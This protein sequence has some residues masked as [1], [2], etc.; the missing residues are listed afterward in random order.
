MDSGPAHYKTSVIAVIPAAGFGT[1]INPDWNIDDPLL[2]YL[3]KPCLRDFQ[4]GK[5]LLELVIENVEPLS[6]RILVRIGDRIDFND[7]RDLDRIAKMKFKI[8]HDIKEV[9]A[10]REDVRIFYNNLE[11]KDA[12]TG[13]T[14]VAEEAKQ[15]LASDPSAKAV[16]IIGSD[17]PTI[18]SDELNQIIS[19]H[20]SSNNDVTLVSV[21]EDSAFEH[22]RIVRMPYMIER[23][24]RAGPNANEVT[25]IQRLLNDKIRT[26]ELIALELPRVAQSKPGWTRY[27]LLE[28]DDLDL[29]RREG[30]MNIH[31]PVVGSIEQDCIELTTEA[32]E[33]LK[34]RLNPDEYVFFGEESGTFLGIIEQGQIGLSKEDR[35]RKSEIDVGGFRFSAE[36]LNSIRERNVLCMVV[37]REV[38]LKTIR[39]LDSRNYG[40]VL[41]SGGI[42]TVVPNV[43]FMAMGHG[44]TLEISGLKFSRGDLTRITRCER[45]ASEREDAYVLERHEKDEYY[46]PEVANVVKRN[47]GRVGVFRLQRGSAKGMD[48]RTDLRQFSFQKNHQVI[49]S[50][51]K[52]GV[53]VRDGSW[54]GFGKGFDIDG[55]QPGVS[56][57]G[58][59][60]LKGRIFLESGASL[61]DS[62]IIASP[63]NSLRIGRDS[64]VS[65][66]IIRDSS[67]GEDA[68]VQDCAL[69]C[70][71]V[72]RHS[73]A[74]GAIP[75]GSEF[76]Q[77]TMKLVPLDEVGIQ[78][79]EKIFGVSV[80]PNAIIRST[81]EVSSFL[82]SLMRLTNEL[83]GIKRFVSVLGDELKRRRLSDIDSLAEY[84]D[85]VFEP[86]PNSVLRG[87]VALIPPLRLGSF[88]DLLDCTIARSNLGPFA[89]VERSVVTNCIVQSQESEISRISYEELNGELIESGY[90]NLESVD[91]PAE[92]KISSWIETFEDKGKGQTLMEEIYG[93]TEIAAE[94]RKIYLSVLRKSKKI[95][96]GDASVYLIRTPGRVNLMGRHVDH[97]GCHVNPIA[98][99]REII[100]IAEPRGDSTVRAWDVDMSYSPGE[101]RIGEELPSRKLTEEEWRT[102]TGELSEKRKTRTWMDYLRTIGFAVNMYKTEAG[103]L[104]KDLRGANVVVFGDILK[105][106]GL[107]SSSALVVA[108]WLTLVA[109][110]RLR[111]SKRRLVEW[112]GISEWYVGTR[113]GMGDHAAMMFGK[114][115]HISQIGFFPL[116][117]SHYKFPDGYKIVVCDSLVK[118]AKMVGAKDTFNQR[119][120]CYE[121]ALMLIRKMYPLLADRIKYFRDLDPTSLGISLKQLYGILLSLPE[122]MTRE[123][124]Y[125]EL[126]E[127]HARLERLFKEH[128][129]PMKGYRIRDIA[130]FGISECARSRVAPTI[131]EA[132]IESFGR[133]MRISHGGDRKVTF[134]GGNAVR[135]DGSVRKESIEEM[136]ARASI[137]TP[138]RFNEADPILLHGFYDCGS[139]QVDKI[140]EISRSIEGVLGAQILGAGL[141]GCVGILVENSAVTRLKQALLREY[142]HQRPKLEESVIVCVPVSGAQILRPPSS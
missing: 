13:A 75:K 18:G 44:E 74:T 93:E 10:S 135:Y 124:L 56:L 140:V 106:A 120:A 72:A 27:L 22:G 97:R 50:L 98:I 77:E 58:D 95:L 122:S 133:L 43:K 126:P 38:F 11:G 34:L 37:S 118:A 9:L 71:D 49:D 88:S 30:K 102:L 33:R 57:S 108:I 28:K 141:G 55:I 35:L 24:I 32:I 83:G 68:K 1:R 23:I 105:A 123:E 40:R 80:H 19:Y 20:F 25:D 15:I 48:S 86:K 117:V 69:V 92:S 52:R 78:A 3:A 29:I 125:L 76:S 79:L 73:T 14:I 101:F 121:I 136:M 142:Y 54:I 111:I 87:R 45:V 129:E 4:S 51:R 46:L 115:G 112:A 63:D 8:Q 65:R 104:R 134:R 116:S 70:K 12:G 89:V 127:E 21:T 113:G 82:N 61:V 2:D 60:H 107:S 110:N 81:A 131:L 84:S 90:P 100:M 62:I 138:N 132:S 36:Y 7:P 39:D 26:G 66:A 109:V 119:V 85:L 130:V 96:G 59:I 94:R 64:F 99:P 139:Q 103:I 31:H 17:L 128:S 67:V 41:E 42:R 114:K 137:Q 53:I 91:V 6:S 47:S 16:L 5:T